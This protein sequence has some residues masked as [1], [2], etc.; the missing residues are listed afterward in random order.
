MLHGC[1]PLAG[2]AS[3]GAV[4]PA[5]GSPPGSAA[6]PIHADPVPATTTPTEAPQLLADER[7]RARNSRLWRR[8][9]RH[10]DAAAR[11]QLIESLMGLANAACQRRL[12]AGVPG[13]VDPDDMLSAAYVALIRAVDRF[14][15]DQGA[16]IE[17][18]VWNRCEGAV[19]DLIRQQSP[20]TRNLRDYERRCDAVQ[21]RLGHRPSE[22]E[23]A[24]A[25]ELPLEQV[26]RRE[27]E[28][29][30]RFPISLD[31]RTA[32]D[33]EGGGQDLAATLPAGDRREDPAACLE[34]LDTARLVRSAVGRLPEKERRA[35][36]GPALDDA[37]LSQVSRELGVSASRVSQLRAR[38]IARLHDELEPHRELVLAA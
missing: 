32:D 2:E 11:G 30:N 34:L 38:A 14:D 9:R 12:R 27:V 35:I 15:A 36:A 21:A 19:L 20:G 37:P 1:A 7:R 13:F 24:D 33:G 6:E 8:W 10:G 18:F 17:A 29:A 31:E 25:L 16:P 3:V 4:P 26:R 28:R 23:L 5:G 22:A